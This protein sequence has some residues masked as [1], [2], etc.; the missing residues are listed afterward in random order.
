M[1]SPVPPPMHRRERLT[2]VANPGARHD[3]L[4]VLAGEPRPGI[5]LEIRYVPDRW[6]AEP[7]GFAAYL[8]ALADLPGGLE[9]LA[10]AVLDDVN[11]ELV[12]RWAEVRAEGADPVSHRVVVEDRQPGWDNPHVFARLERL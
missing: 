1:P 3:Y 5:R 7:T 8:G 12:P 11:N 2:T 4:I 9:A 10:L 6:V